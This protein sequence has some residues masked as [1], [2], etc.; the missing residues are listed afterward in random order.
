MIG[1]VAR[2]MRA[3]GPAGLWHAVA[4]RV[5]DWRDGRFDRRLGIDTSFEPGHQ[6]IQIHV[7][8]RIVGSAPIVPG[9]W[10]FVDYGCGKGRALVL[11]AER[12]FARARGIELGPSLH[13]KAL[14]NIGSYRERRPSAAPIEVTLGDAAQLEPPGDESVLFFYNPFDASTLERVLGRLHAGWKE[15][16]ADWFL[17]YRTP[18]HADRVRACSWLEPVVERPDF[19]IWRTRRRVAA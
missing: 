9:R 14:R 19:C 16:D 18:L 6:P 10:S 2:R 13:A 4:D 11:A 15:R 3:E 8:D 7:F 1:R 5:E 17:A 12:G